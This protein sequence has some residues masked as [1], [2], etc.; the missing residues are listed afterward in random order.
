MGVGAAEEGGEVVVGGEVAVVDE[1]LA[2]VLGVVRP[3][4]R[5]QHLPVRAQP[6]VRHIFASPEAWAGLDYLLLSDEHLIIILLLVLG[7]IG[8][9]HCKKYYY[10]LRITISARC[11]SNFTKLDPYH[12][13]HI[14][15]HAL[16]ILSS[17]ILLSFFLVGQALFSS[18][19]MDA[20]GR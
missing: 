2:G 16:L 11:H 3:R 15:R 6:R 19:G 1:V 17:F 14:F 9:N 13:R 5:R 7:L 10:Y 4:V 12:H 18:P 8:S 20:W